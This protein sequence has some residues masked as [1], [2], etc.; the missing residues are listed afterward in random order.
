MR[1]KFYGEK[2]MVND[3]NYLKRR[4]PDFT[5]RFEGFT[6][7]NCS[8]FVEGHTLV[9]SLSEL[10]T[11]E[12]NPLARDDWINSKD[13]LNNHLMM[14]IQTRH[15]VK[16][17]HKTK[18]K[19]EFEEFLKDIL[20]INTV[21]VNLVHDDLISIQLNMDYEIYMI[22]IIR[23]LGLFPNEILFFK[24]NGMLKFQIK[25]DVMDENDKML[26]RCNYE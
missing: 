6:E 26:N 17:W 13:Y 3:Y 19:T 14:N 10:P 4:L 1:I 24:E 25:R 12:F 16:Y 2:N 23:Q 8:G 20:D 5:D 22:D 9:D 15:I 18:C 11:F 21:H 7:V